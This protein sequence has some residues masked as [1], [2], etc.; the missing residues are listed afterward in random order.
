MCSSL[1]YRFFFQIHIF[2][3]PSDIFFEIALNFF[4]LFL[5]SPFL[6]V[7]CIFSFPKKNDWVGSFFSSSSSPSRVC[8]FFRKTMRICK[9]AILIL[10]FKIYEVVW[11]FWHEAFYERRV[12][13]SY[14]SLP[15]IY[16]LCLNFRALAYGDADRNISYKNWS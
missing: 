1:L 2:S 12:G 15:E 10:L 7:I 3:S 13:V 9:V 4:S 6:V 11:L 8:H 16:N 5:L 14:T